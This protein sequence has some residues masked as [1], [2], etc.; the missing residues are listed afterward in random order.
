MIML[1][2]IKHEFSQHIE[3]AKATMV[4][5]AT[6]IESTVNLCIQ[7]LNSGGKIILLGNGGSAADAQHIAAELVCR[8]KINRKGLAAI[9]ITTDTSILTAISNDYG[10][11]YVFN[12]QLEAIANKQDVVIGISTSGNSVNVINALILANEI[13]CT[14]IG[15]SGINNKKMS[16]LCNVSIA[17]PDNDTPRIQEMHIVIGH[18]ICHLIEQTVA[19]LEKPHSQKQ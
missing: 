10:Y 3:T 9:A 14:T 2:V 16:P 5:I 1:S 4:A 6:E 18:T 7:S 15:F 11:E 19:S 13:G 8:Y 12:R 17:V